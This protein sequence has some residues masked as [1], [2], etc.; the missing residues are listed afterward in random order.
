M[1]RKLPLYAVFISLACIFSYIESL[2][3]FYF[4]VPGM[5]LGLPNLVVLI[6][7]YQFGPLSAIIISL[8]R[9]LL[10]GFMFGNAFSI[11]YSIAGACLSFLVMF[12]LKKYA[13]INIILISIFGGIFHNIGQLIIAI[14]I[15]DNYHVAYYAPFLIIA[16]IICGFINGIIANEVIKR[17]HDFIY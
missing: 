16:G 5:K 6:V 13:K 12:L 2:I 4:G 15:V 17:I 10:T 9:V 11:I 1:K 3:P 7:L 8:S 14:L